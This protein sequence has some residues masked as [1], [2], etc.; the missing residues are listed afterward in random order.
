MDKEKG[1]DYHCENFFESEKNPFKPE[2]NGDVEADE[3]EENCQDFFRGEKECSEENRI[4]MSE[5][6][7][8]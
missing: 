8:A 5:H 1:T 7:G 3:V 2:G 6:L 4:E